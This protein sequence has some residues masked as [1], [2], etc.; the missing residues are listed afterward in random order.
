MYVVIFRARIRELD[1]EYSALA[2][3][4]RELAL[5]QFGCLEFQ[6]VSEGRDEVALSYW[7][8]PDSIRA[9]KRQADHLIAQGK[10]RSRWYE[11]YSVQVAQVE[12]EYRSPA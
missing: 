2:A 11:S 10:G 8:D 4:L 5:K 3:Q 9:W 12:R 1:A 7:P 6:A